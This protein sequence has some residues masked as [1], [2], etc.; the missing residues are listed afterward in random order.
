MANAYFYSNI[1][2]PTTLSGNINNSVTSCTVASTTGWPS[3]T[4]FIV[5]LDFA[6]ANEELIR[7]TV[8]AAGTLTMSRGFG[9][10]SA[11][12]HSTGAV[13]RCV[14]NAQDA[15]DFRTHEA[16]AA[17]VHGVAGALV[18]TTDSQTLTNKTITAPAISNPAISGGGSMA[19]TFAGTPTFSGNLVFSGAPVFSGT[20]TLNLGATVSGGAVAVTR[21]AAANT[22]L[23]SQVAA[24]TNARLLQ[25]A[26]GK[27]LWGP[28][29]TAGDSV[30]YREG[31]KQLRLDDTLLRSYR[32]NAT[33]VAFGSL[34]LA[35]AVTRFFSDASGKLQW[36]NGT[37]VVDTFLYRSGVGA[38][39]TDG[40]FAAGTFT[41]TGVTPTAGWTVTSEVFRATCGVSFASLVLNRSGATITNPGGSTG[42]ISP[43][44]QLM[45]GVP[46]SWRP[47]TA[48]YFTAATGLNSGA[49]R[50]NT[51]GSVD[52]TDWEPGQDIANNANLRLSWTLI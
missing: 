22:A 6:T 26:D 29:N 3:S 49:G 21:A 12:S 20:P 31:V 40:S 2:V 14:Y 45:T 50:V 4:P 35:D 30:L 38:L 43:D 32:T 52:L 41:Q 28:G 37:A 46:A 44:L 9:G 47:T 15:T 42:N 5:A 19:G 25:Q 34:T 16:A 48:L 11:V 18:G 8:N 36:G 39:T 13:V 33:D 7:V 23:S 24:D 17:A 51:D 10:T 27:L 1:A